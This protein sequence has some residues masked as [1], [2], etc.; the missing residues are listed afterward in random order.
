MSQGRPDSPKTFLLPFLLLLLFAAS[1]PE[2]LSG[3]TFV[4]TAILNPLGFLLLIGL[5]GCGATLVWE[6]L[7]RWKRGW[8]AVVPL[9]YAYGIAEEG[10][11]TKVFIDPHQQFVITG[12]AGS[13][14]SAWGVQWFPLIGVG[15]FH[16]V[17][18]VGMEL[19]LIALLFPSLKGRSIL[20]NRA[21]VPVALAFLA[22]VTLMFFT[23]DKDPL[24]PLAA[25][26]I[27]MGALGA[28]LIGLGRYFPER[29][30]A[31]W[32]R[33]PLPTA[34]PRAFF[35]VGLLWLL[36]FLVLFQIGAH[37]VPWAFL[38]IAIFLLEGAGALYFLMTRAGWRENRPQQVAFLGGLAVGF[39][40]WDVFIEILG[41][42][43]VLAVTAILLYIVVWLWRHPEGWASYGS[44]GV[45]RVAP[46]VPPAA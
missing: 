31:A 36:P 32:M 26:L 38:L 2:F 3:S 8:L 43:G 29:W 46:A 34:S 11:G 19:L 9:G 30:V 39:L 42:I 16:A 27:V 4:L 12:I 6:A 1:F 45:S 17:V 10:F 41:D 44:P 20:S 37:L 13:Y 7:A 24:G 25:S 5:Y 35:W 22:T 15:I 23:T 40:V 18:S 14:G 28:V 33:S 21:L